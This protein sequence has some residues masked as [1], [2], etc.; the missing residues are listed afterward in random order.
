[1]ES[2]GG[3]F[4]ISGA[5]MRPLGSK[6]LPGPWLDPPRTLQES[7]LEA[8]G[9]DLGSNLSQLA[10][11]ANLRPTWANSRQ[12][13]A[14]LGQL[15]ANLRQLEANLSQLEA[16]LSQLE[17]NLS[18]LEAILTSLRPSWDHLGVTSGTRYLTSFFLRFDLDFD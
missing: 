7:L 5:S 12:H 8:P 14:I 4:G 2:P 16:N 10:T 13:E 18:H 11:R 6:C 1:M 17:A 9:A 3:H 15:E